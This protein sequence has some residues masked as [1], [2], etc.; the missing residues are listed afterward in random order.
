[1][2][3]FCQIFNFPPFPLLG[4]VTAEH[5]IPAWVLKVSATLLFIS[6]FSFLVVLEILRKMSGQGIFLE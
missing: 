2:L 3:G 1:M 4:G 5:G 6:K